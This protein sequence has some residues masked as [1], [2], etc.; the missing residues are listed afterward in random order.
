V[1]ENSAQK[2]PGQRAVSEELVDQL[3]ALKR[4]LAHAQERFRR[5]GDGGRQRVLESLRAIARFL[6]RFDDEQINDLLQPVYALGW[7]LVQLGDSVRA[8]MHGL[9]R[10]HGPHGRQLR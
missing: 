9:C 3:D 2:S 10:R 1:V 7:A 5:A 4:E 6:H 8:P